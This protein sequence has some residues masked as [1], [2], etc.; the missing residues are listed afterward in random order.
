[1]KTLTEGQRQYQEY[2]QSEHWQRTRA[3]VLNR[4]EDHCERCGRFCGED[5]PDGGSCED[6]GCEWCRTYFFAG[7][8]RNDV[9]AQHLEV[10]H[11]TY[12]RRGR[13]WLA[14]LVALCWSCHKDADDPDRQFA[15]RRW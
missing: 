7:G 12:E 10:H 3:L 11:K 13:E 2:L 8:F 4:A 15:G 9:E 14:D 6:A 5:P 1:M